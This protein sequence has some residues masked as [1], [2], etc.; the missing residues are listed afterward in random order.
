MIIIERQSN[1]GQTVRVQIIDENDESLRE[2]ESDHII[3]CSQK[4]GNK[5]TDKPS[6]H[7]IDKNDERL[8]EFNVEQMMR[9]Q[10]SDPIH[11]S[12]YLCS[13]KQ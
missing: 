10:I 8:P 5:D 6:V 13:D 7:F 2:F 9:S 3:M 12:D 1:L 11:D 4:H